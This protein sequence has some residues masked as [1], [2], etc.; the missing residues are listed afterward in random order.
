[1][2]IFKPAHAFTGLETMKQ[3]ALERERVWS[4]RTLRSGLLSCVRSDGKPETIFPRLARAALV[5]VVGLGL[6]VATPAVAQDKPVIATAADL[7][8]T[9]FELTE[10]PSKLAL[11]GGPA[12]DTLKEAVAADATRILEEYTLEDVTT[13]RRLRSTLSTVAFL[14][15]RWSDVLS[16]N[17]QVKALEDKAAAKETSGLLS[18]AYARA[19]MSAGSDEGDAFRAAFGEEY[20][21]AVNAAD[22]DLAQDVLQSTK[23]SFEI[24]TPA[25]LQGSLEGSFDKNAEAQNMTVDR[26][27]ASAILGTRLTLSLIPLKE[28]IV[29]VLS[30]RIAAE[31]KEKPDLWTERLVSLDDTPDLAPVVIGIWDSGTDPS[32]F[33]DTMWVNEREVLN[34]EDD[35]DNGFVDDRHGI[36][37]DFDWNRSTGALRSMPEE[38]LANL[39]ELL[40][41]VK[42]SL[43]LQASQ[44]T[45]EAQAFRQ[46]ITTLKPEEV[47]PFQLQL[48]RLGLYLHGTA[49]GHVAQRGLPSAQLMHVRFDFDV[50]PVPDP[51]DEQMAEKFSGHVKDTIAY[52]KAH[53]V[54]VVNMS[55]RITTPQIEGSLASVEPDTEKRR[56]RALAIFDTM[57]KA[58]EDG[59]ASA[60]EILFVPG[61][62]NED[63]DIEFVKSFP[64]GINLPNV[65]TVGAIDVSLQP[66]GFTSYGKSIDLYANGF[67]VPSVVPGGKEIRISG[68]SLAAPQVTN[69]AAQLWALKP[70]LTV[71]QVRDLIEDTATIETDQKLRVIT[72]KAAI[73]GL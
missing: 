2:A 28:Q 37:F 23:G 19:A 65:L 63:E 45:E 13:E 35:D 57:N 9:T 10:L 39:D 16:I 11:E 69:L 38:D 49:T 66:A 43:D 8:R 50:K 60:P 61:A 41:F 46:H 33:P 67:E 30:V 21:K 34:G 55:W 56:E 17:E 48:G 58:L 3:F 36:A 42:G 72:P 27:F 20:A 47:L 31:K 18:G 32:V 71:A 51:L 64:A 68:T 26:G 24:L 70:D 14:D 6:A 5:A 44:E 7:P 22:Y 25:L 40:V 52:L 15:K 4:S 62:G 1:M 59:F 12:F 29:E 53:G 54:K 73:D